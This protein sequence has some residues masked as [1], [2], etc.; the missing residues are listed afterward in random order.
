MAP[1][2]TSSRRDTTDRIFEL[3]VQGRKTGVTLQDTGVRDEHGMQPLDD[4]FSSPE[5][6]SPVK[7]GVNG[8]G[9]AARAAQ[10]GFEE[11]SDDSSGQDMDIDNGMF[12]Q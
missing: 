9:P 12:C 6:R 3:G 5:K 8:N 1:R 2:L 4:L 7:F 11:E 10:R